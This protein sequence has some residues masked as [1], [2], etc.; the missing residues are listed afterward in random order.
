[1]HFHPS[2][3]FQLPIMV[4]AFVREWQNNAFIVV[5]STLSRAPGW[6]VLK[7]DKTGGGEMEAHKADRVE[8]PNVSGRTMRVGVLASCRYTV[9][10][11]R[12]A[13]CPAVEF[14]SR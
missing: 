14:R 2:A 1:M 3:T 12:Y 5:A 13:T 11:S 7:P 4:Y 6:A 8:W 9:C 10:T